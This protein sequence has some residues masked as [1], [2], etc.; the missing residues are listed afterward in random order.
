MTFDARSGE[1]FL[2]SHVQFRSLNLVLQQPLEALLRESNH[3]PSQQ[4]ATRAA[5]K[6]PEKIAT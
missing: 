1:W 4:R 6:D 3:A 5:G 2:Q